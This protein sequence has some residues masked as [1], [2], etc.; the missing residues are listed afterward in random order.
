[1]N[2]CTCTGLLMGFWRIIMC[3]S[4]YGMLFVIITRLFC[5]I[6]LDSLAILL[7]FV[8]I[9]LG[10][11]KLMIS[12]FTLPTHLIIFIP[13]PHRSLFLVT[14]LQALELTLFIIHF[15]IFRSQH[16]LYKSPICHSS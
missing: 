2:L 9:V 6:F 1:M 3:H 11:I 7:F 15:Y 16:C 5:F 13:F 12:F 14:F 10:I 8:F 4:R